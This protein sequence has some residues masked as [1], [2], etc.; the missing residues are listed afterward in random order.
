MLGSDDCVEERGRA[1]F[2]ERG[3]AACDPSPFDSLDSR[4][5]VVSIRVNLHCV[6]SSSS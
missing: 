4:L 1:E 5:C 6:F 2:C 3:F